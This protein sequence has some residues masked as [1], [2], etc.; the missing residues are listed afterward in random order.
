MPNR[1]KVGVIWYLDSK[2]KLQ[3]FPCH[4]RRGRWNL[5]EW[6]GFIEVGGVCIEVGVV[7]WCGWGRWSGRGLLMFQLFIS[8]SSFKLYH[9]RANRA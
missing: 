4:L 8:L 7:C 1:R 6:M 3:G 5:L 2:R 9:V